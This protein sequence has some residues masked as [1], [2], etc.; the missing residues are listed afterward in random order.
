MLV[1]RFDWFLVIAALFAVS[2]SGGGGCGGCGMQ[3]IP[4]GFVPAKRN[5]NAAQL[6]VSDS[7]LAAITANPAALVGALTGGGALTFNVPATCT[8]STPV[9]CTGGN[10]VSP[11]GPVNID[12]SLHAGDKPRLEL[13]PKQGAKELD[14][15]VRARVTS[16]M[17]IPVKVPIVGDC[18]IKIDTTASAPADIEIDAPIQFVQDAMA[19]T[20]N[21]I[22]G[23]VALQDLTAS[24]VSLT[25]SIGCQVANFGLGFFLSTLTSQLT[26]VVQSTIQD[27]TCKKCPSGDV[28]ECGSPFATACTSGVCEEGNS[29]FQELGLDGRMPASALFGGFSPGTTGAL[30]LYEVAGGYGTTDSNGIA[31]GLLGGMEPGGQPRDACGPLGTEPAPSSIPESAFFQGNTR[32]DTGDPFGVAIGVHKSQLSQLAFAGYNGGLF[33]LTVSHAKISQLT[34]DTIGLLSRSLGKLV[35]T[36]SP[37]AVGLRPQSAPEITLGLNTFKDDGM[38]NQVLD[39]AL[40]DIKFT[41]MEIDFFVSIDDQYIRAFTVVSDVHLPIGL[42]VSGMGQL[43]PVI[44]N[45]KDAFT[46]ISVKNTQAVTE[47]PEDLAMLFPTI[48]NL[49]IPQLSNG[50]GAISLPSLGGLQLS[51]NSITAVDNKSFL[52]IFA[53]LSAPAAAHPVT[54]HADLL[55]ITEPDERIAASPRL[56]R[57]AEPPSVT[58]ALGGDAT[59]L[60]WQWRSDGGM[61]HPWSKNPQP[62]I[63]DRTYWLRGTHHLEVRARRIGH[64]ETLDT[65]GTTL[66]LPFGLAAPSTRKS[67]NGGEAGFHGQAGSAGCACDSGGAGAG[68]AAPFALAIA[69]LFLTRRARRRLTLRVRLG[70]TTWLVALAALPGCDCSSHPCGDATCVAG[71]IPHGAIGRFTSIAG[72]DQRV[73]VATYDQTLGDLVAVDATDPA[74]LQL[75]V[76]D[77]IPDG[78]QPT[79]DPSGYRGGVDA[80]GPNVGAFTSIAIANGTARIAYQDRDLLALKYAFET[81]PGSWQSYVV[82]SGDGVP[83]GAYASLAIDGNGHPAIAY[84]AVGVDDMMGHRNTE[85]RIARAS[86]AAPAL[87]NWTTSSI[88]SAPG[89]CAGACDASAAC[90][91]GAA[92]GDPEECVTATADCSAACSDTQVCSAGAC[93]TKIADPTVDVPPSGIGMYVSL[94]ALPDG[95]LAAAYYDSIR[96]ALVLSVESAEGSN[97]FAETL[98]DGNVAGRDVGMWASAVAGTDGTVHV[99]YQDALGD[100]LMYT[101]WTQAGAGVPEVVDDGERPGERTHPVGAAASIYLVSGSPAIV[102]QDGMLADVML[103][104]RSGAGWSAS[105]LATGPLLDGFSI[106]ATTG[107]GGTPVFAWESLDP[108]LDPPNALVVQK[109]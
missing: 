60:E 55:S 85:L 47:S 7:G 49:V 68:Q 66:E 50:L 25:G 106:G 71:D 81:S 17:D 33:C 28:A 5:P 61:W 86:Q 93:L 108:A 82:D 98:L 94:I 26:G 63:G 69:L 101:T 84:L 22:V 19:G 88:A 27:Q 13:H 67:A 42:Q 72:D 6:R 35:E 58:L 24:D 104:T 59:D 36:S 37:V 65:V 34:T 51:V 92:A 103:A 87:A 31:L 20:T 105:G 83:V 3:P 109:P 54:T 89:S 90:V 40:L 102:Y 41:A 44:G 12:L 70:A 48:L 45:V 53:D 57:D 95:R 10:P 97:M 62:T 80:A 73:M 38:G 8:G 46:N 77:G 96:R 15:V 30:D 99:A 23:T 21:V 39:E 2:C 43:V 64:P 14:V 91:A 75:T 11:C 56:W 18:G 52:A 100:Q 107:H 78:V 9:C 79:H 76:V 32:P 16:T 29:C 1:R 4:G 74:N